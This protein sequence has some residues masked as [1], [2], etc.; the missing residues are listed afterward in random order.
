MGFWSLQEAKAMATRLEKQHFE[1]QQ[2]QQQQQQLLQ[3]ENDE[4][5][6]SPKP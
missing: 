6:V 2:Q 3:S 4:L 1:Q 5:H